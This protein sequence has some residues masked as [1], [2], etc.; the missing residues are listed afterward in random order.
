MGFAAGASA[1]PRHG[2]APRLGGSWMGFG[3]PQVPPGPRELQPAG[4]ARRNPEEKELPM[5][6]W[7]RA[8]PPHQLRPLSDAP[9]KHKPCR[10]LWVQPHRNPLLPGTAP[11]GGLRVLSPHPWV[12][13]SP[14]PPVPPQAHAHWGLQGQRPLG[15]PAVSGARGH[16]SAM[17]LGG[18]RTLRK[19]HRGQGGVGDP[20]VPPP[21]GARGA[22]GQPCQGGAGS[23]GTSALCRVC[24]SQP[25]PPPQVS[26]ARDPSKGT[27]GGHKTARG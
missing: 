17:G 15:P 5:R 21:C 25:R 13:P 2:S 20:S 14:A 27:R 24:S 4:S 22:L 16:P 9:D 8:P 1:A 12:G 18:Q 11:L 10:V 26:G 19:E 23:Q 3:A 6:V 7:S